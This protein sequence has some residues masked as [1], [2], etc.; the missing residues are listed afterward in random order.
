MKLASFEHFVVLK[1]FDF[2]LPHLS[3]MRWPNKSWYKK[4][5]LW[6]ERSKLQFEY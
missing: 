2:L 3:Y 6:R 4:R 5:D 1:Y